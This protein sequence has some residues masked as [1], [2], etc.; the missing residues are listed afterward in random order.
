M[1]NSGASGWNTSSLRHYLQS[2]LSTY[3]IHTTNYVLP[4]KTSD[5]HESQLNEYTATFL[6]YYFCKNLSENN[7]I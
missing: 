2:P 3:I 7:L 4:G 5:F 6:Y 1:E